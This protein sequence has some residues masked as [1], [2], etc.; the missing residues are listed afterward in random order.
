MK[1]TVKF[2]EVVWIV[3]GVI[4]FGM[5]FEMLTGKRGPVGAAGDRSHSGKML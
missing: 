5:D 4:V 1:S 2:Q 3:I